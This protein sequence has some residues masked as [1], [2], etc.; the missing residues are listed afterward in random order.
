[1]GKDHDE[2]Q[3]KQQGIEGIEHRLYRAYDENTETWIQ[4]NATAT[5]RDI[6]SRVHRYGREVG[7]VDPDDDTYDSSDDKMEEEEDER[8]RITTQRGLNTPHNADSSLQ[9]IKMQG[10]F[11]CFVLARHASTRYGR[12]LKTLSSD[13]RPP[14]GSHSI[15][16]PPQNIL[17]S[18]MYYLC[19]DSDDAE[20]GLGKSNKYN[21]IPTHLGMICGTLYEHGLTTYKKPVKVQD[22]LATWS[23]DPTKR[24]IP[25]SIEVDLPRLYQACFH[26]KIFKMYRK[27]VQVWTKLLVTIAL[28]GWKSDVCGRYCPQLDH[29]EL[30]KDQSAFWSDTTPKYIMVICFCQ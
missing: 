17:L 14:A 6:D 30:P 8:L 9:R 21:T 23:G 28:I 18:Y 11:E 1:L 2:E 4:S 29:I 3:T 12:F 19:D 27:R 5:K 7:F 16:A 15:Q 10:D 13:D 24:A 26:S 22:V 25:L 20:D